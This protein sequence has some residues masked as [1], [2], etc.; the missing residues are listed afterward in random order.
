MT[1]KSP[2][3][4]GPRP[5]TAWHTALPAQVR[6]AP[7]LALLIHPIADVLGGEDTVVNTTSAKRGIAE[8]KNKAQSAQRSGRRG[9][10]QWGG[11]TKS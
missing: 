6:E 2:K 3:P 9:V 4:G 10:F 7:V 8:S 11:F 5:H 1:R